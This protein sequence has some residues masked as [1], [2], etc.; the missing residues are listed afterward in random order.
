MGQTIW[1]IA[2]IADYPDTQNW[3]TLHSGVDSANHT[4]N[5]GQNLSRDIAQQQKVQQQQ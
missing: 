4:M 3:T 2:W 5:Y 1:S